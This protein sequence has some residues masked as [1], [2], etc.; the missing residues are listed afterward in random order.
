M[1]FVMLWHYINELNLNE[2]NVGH[3]SENQEN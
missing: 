2:L 1:I 3:L